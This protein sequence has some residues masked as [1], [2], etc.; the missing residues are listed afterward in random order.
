LTD[1][2]ANIPNHTETRFNLGSMNKMFTAVA[3]LQLVE[4]G[5]LRLES[6]FGK[7]LPDYPNAAVAKQVTIHHLLTHTSGLGD[8]F[9]DQ[10][11]ANPNQYRSNQDFLP[12]F[13][14]EPLLFPPGERFL[15]SNAG[16]VVLGLIIEKVSGMSYDAYVR[17]NIFEPSGMSDTAAFSV[18]DKVPNRAIGYT[19]QDFYGNETGLL[20][21]NTAL[22]PGKGFAAGGGYSTAPDLLK[23]GNA[24]FGNRLLSPAAIDLLT[25]GKVEIGENSQYAYGFLNRAEGEQRMVGHSGGAPGVCSSFNYY[26]GTGY[27][28]IVLSNSDSDCLEVLDY[29]KDHPLTQE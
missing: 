12:L 3:I 7:I 9:T 23:F 6:T 29:V 21:D 16:Y 1:R 24:L 19:T 5:R 27:T 14:D 2:Q 10:F 8:V 13:V 26:P 11:A 20:T 15:Y 17:Q 28:V 4:D 25:T 18:D 22:M